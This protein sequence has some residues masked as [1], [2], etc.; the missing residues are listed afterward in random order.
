M[1]MLTLYNAGEIFYKWISVNGFKIMTK[2]NN[3]QLYVY[4]MVLR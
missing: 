4:G 3:S 1:T 2:L